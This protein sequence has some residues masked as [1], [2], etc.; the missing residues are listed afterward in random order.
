LPLIRAAVNGD[1]LAALRA[2]A[3]REN[4][5][6]TQSW[7]P[8]IGFLHQRHKP[9]TLAIQ[10]SKAISTESISERT[11]PAFVKTDRRSARLMSP[12]IAHKWARIGGSPRQI[13]ESKPDKVAD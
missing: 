8:G 12:P 7:E 13:K 10:R 9:C 6:R 2:Q 3:E 11:G 5:Q 1:V 4:P